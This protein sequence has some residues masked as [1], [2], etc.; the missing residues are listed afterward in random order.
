[1]LLGKK[2]KGTGYEIPIS[3]SDPPETVAR[4]WEQLV[5]AFQ[6]PRTVRECPLALLVHKKQKN[7]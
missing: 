5:G 6:R 7:K 4:Q 1:M 3:A 2:L